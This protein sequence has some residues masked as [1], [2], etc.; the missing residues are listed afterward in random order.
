MSESSRVQVLVM[1]LFVVAVQLLA[2]AVT[3]AISAS[4][5]RVFQDPAS[6]S[7]PFVYMLL[8]LAF[9]ALLLVAIKKNKGW[10]VSGF[11]QLSIAASIYYLMVAFMSPLLALLPTL[12]VLLLLRYYP[13][14]YIIDAFG[15]AVCAGISS[16][17]GV[18]MTPLPA[19]LLLIILAIYDALSVYKTRHMVSLAE[20]VIKIK[21]PLLFVVPKSRDYSFRKDP[22]PVPTQADG[23]QAGVNP[24]SK[25]ASGKKGAYFLGLGDAIIPTILVISANTS[26]PAGGFLGA[27]LPAIG[28]MLGTYLGFLLLM[29]TSRDRPQAGLPFLNSGVILGFLAGCALA[30]IR[31]F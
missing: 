16:L 7:N 10:I 26:L 15:I 8:I 21:A 9:T 5:N 4:D 17:F 20:G 2:L 28:A 14:W 11:I 31:P 30:G 25:Q 1:L 12:A 23:N 27:N 13:E 3:P 6:T 18:S 19:L 24:N 29:T 22:M